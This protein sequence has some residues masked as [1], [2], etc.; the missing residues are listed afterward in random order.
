MEAKTISDDSNLLM[1]ER[2]ESGQAEFDERRRAKLSGATEIQQSMVTSSPD[3]TTK[4]GLTQVPT[5]FLNI[6]RRLKLQRLRMEGSH[7]P[8]LKY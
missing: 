8:P 1:P 6:W 7:D 5:H 3:A 2:V 4:F